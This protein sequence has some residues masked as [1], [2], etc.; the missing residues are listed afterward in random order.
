MDDST[1]S[2]D[3]QIYHLERRSKNGGTN[4]HKIN[5]L[6]WISWK[7]IEALANFKFQVSMHRNL[8]NQN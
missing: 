7:S 1:G 8:S 4:E 5:R 3:Q 2:D 6:A